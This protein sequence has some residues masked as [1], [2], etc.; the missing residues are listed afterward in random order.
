M[1]RIPG[2]P[3]VYTT[4]YYTAPF[5]VYT[6]RNGP[7]VAEYMVNIRIFSRKYLP[8]N[9][10]PAPITSYVFMGRKWISCSRYFHLTECTY[11]YHRP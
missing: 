4:L 7:P 6:K 8:L 9:I 5:I 2:T 10:P 11:I 3:L 1:K